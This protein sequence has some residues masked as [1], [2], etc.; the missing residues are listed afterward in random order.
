M[1]SNSENQ[2]TPTPEEI[3]RVF[4]YLQKVLFTYMQKAQESSNQETP[5]TPQTRTY[6][7]KRYYNNYGNGYYKGR[8]SYSGVPRRSNYKKWK[9]Q[10][11]GVP[12]QIDDTDDQ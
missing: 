10:Y 2:K 1:S 7:R 11:S 4:S 5:N 9:E 6:Y 12:G 3:E 8:Y